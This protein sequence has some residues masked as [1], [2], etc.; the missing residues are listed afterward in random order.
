[1]DSQSDSTV[2]EPAPRAAGPHL[3]DGLSALLLDGLLALRKGDFSVRL[4][5]NLTG[6]EGWLAETFNEIASITARRAKGT[7]ASDAFSFAQPSDEPRDAK[8]RAREQE[9]LRLANLELE[10]SVQERA[11][12]LD[13]A[14]RRI[15]DDK[16]RLRMAL[17]IAQIAAWEWHVSSGQMRWSTDPELPFGFPH[18][19]LGHDL[20]IATAAHSDDERLV[21][22]ALA[23]AF[24]S[25]AYEAEYRAVR[26]NGSIAWIAERGRVLSDADGTRMV[27]ISRDVTAER[28]LAMECERLLQREREAREVAERQSSLRDEFLA[29]VSH[30][31]RTP[32][33]AVLGW[34]SILESAASVRN[35][36]FVLDVI[37]RNAQIQLKLIEDLLDMNH[38]L[39]G[40]LR[41]EF[42]PVN[43]AEILR[44]TVQGLQPEAAA[45]GVHVTVRVVSDHTDLIADSRRLRQVLSNLVHNAIKFT[46]PQGRV[47]VCVQ[48]S[49]NEVTVS[50]QD[51][52]QGISADF[53][54]HV[55]ERF[56]QQD[57][58]STR[59]AS[60]LGLGLSIVK[61]L[62]ELHSG[63]ITVRSAGIGLG[64]TFVVRI[65]VDCH[66][67]AAP[68]PRTPGS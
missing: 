59:A 29:T 43:V 18:G 8:E 42:A 12:A 1:M 52:G 33:N 46:P 44:A 28:E 5:L 62:V 40:D 15:R 65:P 55:F 60:G 4:P 30:E 56:R 22:R 50:V 47:D 66:L 64:A 25:G 39:S 14:N 2:P 32:M 11:A 67:P 21:E 26:P 34:L 31:L 49:G 16:E 38:L 45:K 36:R 58:S 35:P 19:S 53:L 61:K 63:T 24:A 51:S 68:H 37:R 10:R 48:R 54:P 17:D 27:G 57:G 7:D 9:M 41:L 6:I 23:A 3:T 20:R 13:R